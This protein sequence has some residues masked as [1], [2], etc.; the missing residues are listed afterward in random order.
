MTTF[1]PRGR[2][3]SGALAVIALAGCFP[4]KVQHP[5]ANAHERLAD[6]V[7]NALLRDDMRPVVSDFVPERKS[8]LLD[9]SQVFRMH[10]YVRGD[11]AFLGAREVPPPQNRHTTTRYFVAMFSGADVVLEMLMTES[12]K[13]VHYRLGAP[14]PS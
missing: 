1:P 6:D 8:V 5:P 7:M 10:E 2:A 14:P 13:I 4:V 12:G 3:L 11:G 9:P